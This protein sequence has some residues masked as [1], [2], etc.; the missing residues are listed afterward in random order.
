MP[1]SARTSFTPLCRSKS[2]DVAGLFSFSSSVS[3]NRSV[4]LFVSIDRSIIVP[5][6]IGFYFFLKLLGS[7][8]SENLR[9]LSLSTAKALGGSCFPGSPRALACCRWR[10]AAD[11]FLNRKSFGEAPKLAREGACAPQ[12]SNRN[13]QDQLAGCR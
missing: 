7:D 6:L 13:D 8:I 3:V 9:L 1:I 12:S 5:V 4:A 2:G 10:L 11:F